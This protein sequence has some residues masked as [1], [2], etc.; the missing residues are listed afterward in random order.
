MF[1][2]FLFVFFVKVGQSPNFFVVFLPHL[3][4]PGI[5]EAEASIL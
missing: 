4:N 3:L 5:K 1:F 2:V